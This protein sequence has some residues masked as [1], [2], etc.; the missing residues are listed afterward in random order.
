MW[1]LYKAL[2]ILKQAESELKAIDPK[3]VSSRTN[4]GCY[5]M[6]VESILT[7]VINSISELENEKSKK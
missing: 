1:E 5:L 3:L 7:N 4:A 2:N 6:G